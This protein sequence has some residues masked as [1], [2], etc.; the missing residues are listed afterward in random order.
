M[1]HWIDLDTPHGTVRA[2]NEAPP[3]AAAGGVV[4]VQEIF[5]VNAHIRD[6]A[7]RLAAEGFAVLA[8]SV[9]DPVEPGVELDYDEAGVA[10]GR[11]LVAALGFDRAVDIVAAAA[12]RLRT[13]TPRVAAVG[14]CWGGT[15]AFLAAT[16]LGLPA[17][18]YYGGRSVPFLDEPARAPLLM[19]FG[20]HDPIIPAADR[21]LHREKQPQARIHVYDAGHGFNCDR[22]ADYSAAAAALAWRRTCDFLRE[23]LA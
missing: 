7:A 10:R 8:P 18:D 15:V 13:G 19:H 5:G 21:A 6:V 17:V 3:A 12:G 1:G 20:E 4:L 2:W 9:C 22:R 11:E 14:F 16:R 23:V